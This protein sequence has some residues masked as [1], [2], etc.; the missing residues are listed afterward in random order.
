MA[1]IIRPVLAWPRA[2]AIYSKGTV[3]PGGTYF[4]R[5]GS[6][7]KV[8]GELT[9]DITNAFDQACRALV[10]EADSSPVI[11]LGDIETLGSTHLGILAANAL[12]AT[13]EGKELVVRASAALER[14]MKVSEIDRL[15]TIEFVDEPFG[16]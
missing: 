8:V 15:A 16:D 1:V 11:D 5:E 13:A 6:T 3:L 14:V 7:L 9:W 10:S 2:A 12:E 4:I